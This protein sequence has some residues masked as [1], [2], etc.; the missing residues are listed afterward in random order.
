MVDP[1]AAPPID[2]GST[3]LKSGLMGT[4]KLSANHST[5]TA[6]LPSGDPAETQPAGGR[7]PISLRIHGDELFLSGA[8]HR[9]QAAASSGPDL[10]L[11]SVHIAVDAT[12][13][14]QLTVDPREHHLLSFAS[15]K[16]TKLGQSV[17]SAEGVMKIDAAEQPC[18]VLVEIPEGHNSFFALAFVVRKEFLGAAWHQLVGR[19]GTGGI[20]AERLLDPRAGLRGMEL[21]AA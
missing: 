5:L 20:D 3:V 19:A 7:S 1:E 2:G 21:A 12:S 11:V 15:K 9:W 4:S 14:D 13:P 18:D 17:F 6:A 8:F 10:D 16:V